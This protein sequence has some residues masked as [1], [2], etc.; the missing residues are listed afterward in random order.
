MLRGEALGEQ[1]VPRG[2]FLDRGVVKG[3][4][5]CDSNQDGRGHRGENAPPTRIVFRLKRW[6]MRTPGRVYRPLRMSRCT[7]EPGTRS[8]IGAR[9]TRNENGET[10]AMG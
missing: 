6:N 8:D 10:G 3:A 4:D 5:E 1:L 9:P 7:V 2:G